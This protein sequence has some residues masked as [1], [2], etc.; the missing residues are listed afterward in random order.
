MDIIALIYLTYRIGL[1]AALKGQPKL[2]WR[3]FTVLAWVSFEIAGI[4]IGFSI[5]HNIYMA[6]LLGLAGG[7]GGYLLAK[8]RLDQLPDNMQNEHWTD[9]LGKEDRG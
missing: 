5:S 3:L 9:R 1:K 6:G 2:R 8:Y 4:L 7:A